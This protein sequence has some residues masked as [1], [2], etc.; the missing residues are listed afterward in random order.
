ML[1]TASREPVRLA[2]VFSI[3]A[4]VL[5]V[6][7]NAVSDPVKLLGI[8]IILWVAAVFAT[9]AIA[10]S[11]PRK[12]TRELWGTTL[13]TVITAIPL[14]F[15]VFAVL[16]WPLWDWSFSLTAFYA[17]NALVYGVVIGPVLWFGEV[18][19]NSPGAIRRARRQGQQ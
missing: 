15:S 6:V 19:P 2:A 16:D 18:R 7:T 3:L 14:F 11:R 9:G 13:V 8:V 1:R 12:W 4:I 17:V 10:F 5:F